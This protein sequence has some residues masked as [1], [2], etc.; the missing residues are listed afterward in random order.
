MKFHPTRDDMHEHQ[1]QQ[2][3]FIADALALDF[4]NSVATPVDEPVDSIDNGDGLLQWLE[5]AGLVPAEALAMLRA[6]AL[7]G[8]L[9]AVATQARSLREWFRSFVQTHMGKP[10]D[11]EALPA[12]ESLN[13]LLERDDVYGRIVSSTGA[14]LAGMAMAAPLAFAGIAAVADRGSAGEIRVRRRFFCSEGLRRQPLY[15]DVR[16]PYARP[17]PPLVQHCGVRQPGQSGGAPSAQKR[18]R[19]ALRQCRPGE[20]DCW[21]LGQQDCAITIG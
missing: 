11:R 5:Q 1:P 10:I 8:E 17:A 7:P 2:A 13:R 20:G 15:A 16:R 12:L 4:L 19:H 6:Q 18:S 3:I 14:G 9:D 21:P